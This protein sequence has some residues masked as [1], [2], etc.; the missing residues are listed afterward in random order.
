M[1]RILRCSIPSGDK[2]RSSRDSSERA[3]SENPVASEE[4]FEFFC[5]E[6][7]VSTLDCSRSA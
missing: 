4:G 6:Q 2:G 7:P 3:A 1:R 5:A